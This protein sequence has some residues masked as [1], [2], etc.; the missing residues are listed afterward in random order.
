MFYICSRKIYDNVITATYIR[1][2]RERQ[3]HRWGKYEGGRDKVMD[4]V[5]MRGRRDKVIDGVNMREGGIKGIDGVN[6]RG[7]K[8]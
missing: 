6:M 5:N 1:E 7:G 3:K 4:G 8:G 2:G